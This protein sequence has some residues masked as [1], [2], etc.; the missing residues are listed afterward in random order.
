MD[1]I[2]IQLSEIKTLN[3]N[4]IRDIIN[5]C[6]SKDFCYY[7]EAGLINYYRLTVIHIKVFQMGGVAGNFVSLS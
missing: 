2:P 6:L 7:F 3:K 1:N 4:L 5:A